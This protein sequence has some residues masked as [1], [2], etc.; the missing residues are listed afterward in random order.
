MNN[1]KT[2]QGNKNISERLAEQIENLFKKYEEDNLLDELL[3]VDRTLDTS[4]FEIYSDSTFHYQKG[5][6]L[7]ERFFKKDKCKKKGFKY[8]SF[9]DEDKELIKEFEIFSKSI[10]NVENLSEEEISKYNLTINEY[11]DKIRDL[12]PDIT[13]LKTYEYSDYKLKELKLIDEVQRHIISKLYSEFAIVTF[14]S[15]MWSA[16][17]EIDILIKTIEYDDYIDLIVFPIK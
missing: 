4:F 7:V 8:K 16:L 15:L 10:P 17:D 6:V 2:E 3:V 12:K 1:N 5:V 11:R 14:S 9:K 13:V